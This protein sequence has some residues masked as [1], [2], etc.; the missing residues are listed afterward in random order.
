MVCLI[1]SSL[2]PLRAASRS[3]GQLYTAAVL[4]V[5]QNVQVNCAAISS[6]AVLSISS[7]K[8]VL[9]CFSLYVPAHRMSASMSWISTTAICFY[10]VVFHL[11]LLTKRVSRHHLLDLLSFHLH[12]LPENLSH[13][14]NV[15]QGSPAQCHG[16]GPPPG[17]GSAVLVAPAAGG[18]ALCDTLM[19]IATVRQGRHLPGSTVP[20]CVRRGTLQVVLPCLYQAEAFTQVSARSSSSRHP[21]CLGG[22]PPPSPQLQQC[23]SPQPL[24][25]KC[26]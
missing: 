15:C 8:H 3:T 26:P 14:G 1:N 11:H 12:V 20:D 24:L 16:T 22:C 25:L 21:C 6:P 2:I 17:A 10:L 23:H 9:H 4:G 18:T 13:R 5:V 19:S 7:H